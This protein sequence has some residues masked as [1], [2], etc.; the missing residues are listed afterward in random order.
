MAGSSSAINELVTSFANIQV[1]RYACGAAMTFMFYDYFLTL[2][3]VSPPYEL[4]PSVHP[5]TAGDRVCMGWLAE[6]VRRKAHVPMGKLDSLPLTLADTLKEQIRDH[7][8]DYTR[9][10]PSCWVATSTL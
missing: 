2:S 9:Q 7:A 4:S 1:S 10:L 6:N 5:S 8:V 3:D